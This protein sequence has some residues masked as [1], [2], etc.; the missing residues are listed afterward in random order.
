[1]RQEDRKQYLDMIPR[2]FVRALRDPHG[3]EEY[4]LS[5]GEATSLLA[6]REALLCALGWRLW[7]ACSQAEDY[8]GIIA[9]VPELGDAMNAWKA[10]AF[11][12]PDG[13]QR[14]AR[15]VERHQRE[16]EQ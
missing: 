3:N 11:P 14:E 6:E 15:E 1:M 4:E 8:L 13:D 7:R 12:P 5:E 9:N 16:D 2:V 10:N